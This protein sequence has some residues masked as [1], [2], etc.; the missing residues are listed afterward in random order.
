MD[1]TDDALS[2]QEIDEALR[3]LPDWA[4]Q[5]GGFVTVFKT[6]TSAAAVE[7]MAAVGRVAEDRNHHPDLDWRYN[8][9]FIRYTSHDAGT[10]VT[11][12]D[13][14]AAAA[15]SVAATRIGAVAEPGLYRSVRLAIGSPAPDE[16]EETWRVALGYRRRAPG[17]LTD[18]YGRGPSVEILQDGSAGVPGLSVAVH[19]RGAENSAALEKAAAAGAVQVGELQRGQVLQ[20]RQGNRI[21]LCEE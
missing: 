18:P 14:E 17:R 20:D 19:R 11:A 7:L 3:S 15:T 2:R 16:I 10:V 13:R 21:R 4:Y 6:P 5:L 1:G 9:V 12:R 8:R